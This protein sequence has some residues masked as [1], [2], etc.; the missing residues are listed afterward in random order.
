MAYAQG[1]AN[2]GS[3][4]THCSALP[5]L[6]K[7]SAPSATGL[8]QEAHGTKRATASALGEGLH[9]SSID[10]DLAAMLTSALGEATAKGVTKFLESPDYARAH[11]AASEAE[12]QQH[13]M[14]KK[15]VWPRWGGHQ[16]D[17]QGGGSSVG[18]SLLQCHKRGP[19]RPPDA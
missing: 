9:T 18:F 8:E 2:A 5:G 15:L 13:K 4:S 14:V 12:N 1:M 6:R 17:A 7:P 11:E 16:V 19:P 3:L 10:P